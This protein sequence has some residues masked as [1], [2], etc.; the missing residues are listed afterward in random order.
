VDGLKMKNIMFVIAALGIGAA[1]GWFAAGLTGTTGVSPV[2]DGEGAVATQQARE[3]RAPA[4]P[5]QNA[6]SAPRTMR[7]A[8]IRSANDAG[9]QKRILERRI[10]DLEQGIRIAKAKRARMVDRVKSASNAELVERLMKLPTE[11]ERE[12]ALE[13]LGEERMK[14]LTL[15]ELSRILPKAFE[16]PDEAVAGCKRTVEK[17]GF[18]LGILDSVDPS[19][20]SEEERNHHAAFV[21]NYAS[22]PGLFVKMLNLDA[23]DRV[24][25]GEQLEDIQRLIAASKRRD[26]LLPRERQMLLSQAAKS[27]KVPDESAAGLMSALDEVSKMTDYAWGQAYHGSKEE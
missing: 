4:R 12:K 6:K 20:M 25:W 11:W 10:H 15:A 26:E 19:G 13:Q 22:M 9:V 7:K 2:R 1:A 17:T 14:S 16:V 27:F 3:G 8:P 18:R 23:Y 5:D 21:D 24:T